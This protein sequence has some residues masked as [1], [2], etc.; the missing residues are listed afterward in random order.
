MPV[1][2]RP[3]FDD[4]AARAECRR[5][6]ALARGA[7]IPR[8][9]APTGVGGK[10]WAGPKYAN[11]YYRYCCGGP[12]YTKLAVMERVR[13]VRLPKGPSSERRASTRFPLDLELRYSVA[14][15]AS[16]VES[17]TGHTIDLSSSG[18]AFTPDRPLLI[19]QKLDISIDWPILLDGGIRLQVVTSGVVVRTS[20]TV[21]ALRVKQHEFKTR[22]VGLKVV[23]PWESVG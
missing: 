12:P 17:G 14:G 22:R 16:L 21:T 15:R 4:G 7:S 3:E 9:R 13:Q 23:P 5:F 20:G 6:D 19:G 8:A 1:V 2:V 11:Q 10:G 18:L